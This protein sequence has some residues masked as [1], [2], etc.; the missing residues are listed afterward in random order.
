MDALFAADGTPA[1]LQTTSHISVYNTKMS[2]GWRAF[3]EDTVHRQSNLWF[4]WE[5]YRDWNVPK[6]HELLEHKPLPMDIHGF[7]IVLDEG[8]MAEAGEIPLRRKYADDG[9][10]SLKGRTSEEDKKIPPPPVTHG[11]ARVMLLRLGMMRKEANRHLYEYATLNLCLAAAALSGA[12][13]IKLRPVS[14]FTWRSRP[15]LTLAAALGV[16]FATIHAV[17]LTFATIGVY[18]FMSD[19]VRWRALDR[20]R[21][22]DCLQDYFEAAEYRLNDPANFSAQLAYER[23]K[24]EKKVMSTQAPS[25]EEEAA[26]RQAMTIQQLVLRRDL[27]WVRNLQLACATDPAA[28]SRPRRLQ[29]RLPDVGVVGMPPEGSKRG[30]EAMG[31]L[32]YTS[33]VSDAS[34]CDVH[35]GLRHDPRGYVHPDGFPIFP[36]DRELAVV[37]ARTMPVANSTS[38]ADVVAPQ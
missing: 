30:K 3:V 10:G 1:F 23:K 18:L 15:F 22:H 13:F 7:H 16:G 35:R 26:V 31:K 11:T 2:R 37:R 21:C 8:A 29:N 6:L 9:Q 28:H 34:L 20:V 14:F 27:R 32:D 24:K 36:V 4:R 5:N 19:R 12:A 33:L 25:D 17:R 38:C